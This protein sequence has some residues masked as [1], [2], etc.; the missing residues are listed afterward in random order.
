MS[1][2]NHS[3]QSRRPGM[4]KKACFLND[5]WVVTEEM[6]FFSNEKR[7][8]LPFLQLRG[9]CLNDFACLQAHFCVCSC[10]KHLEQE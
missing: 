4:E 6:C 2:T 1:S 3:A 10:V 5:K 9:L 8:D 7:I